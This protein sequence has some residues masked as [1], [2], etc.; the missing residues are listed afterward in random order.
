M[1]IIESLEKRY[2]TKKFNAN[3]LIPEATITKVK[4]A[5]NLTATSYGLQPL[6]L[7]VIQDKKLQKEMGLTNLNYI[8]KQAGA[9]SKVLLKLKEVFKELEIV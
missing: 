3:K 9:T 5:F 7:V 2:A 8:K 6:K 1:S 4:Y